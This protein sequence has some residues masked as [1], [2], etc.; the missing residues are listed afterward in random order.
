VII[1]AMFALFWV[2]LF[3]GPSE[4]FRFPDNLW[5]M[6]IGQAFEGVVNPFILVPGLP[7]MIDVAFEKHQ[8]QEQRINDYC[9][10]LYTSFLGLG[11]VAGP[12]YGAYVT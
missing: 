3:I 8:H 4:I 9:S 7:E 12:I 5:M 6:G 11:L 2:N 1:A 10:A